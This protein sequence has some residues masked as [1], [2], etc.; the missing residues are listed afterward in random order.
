MKKIDEILKQSPAFKTLLK[1][2]G[3]IIVNDL[4]DEALLVTS[5]FLTLQKDIIVIK[6]NQYE[7]NLLYQQISLINEKD[8]LFFP[9]DESYRIEALASSPELLGQRIDALYQLTTDQPKILITHGQALVRYLP[10]R[11]LFLDNCLNLKTGMQI[12][13]YD[14]QKLLIKA[15]Y[16]SAPRVDQPFYFSQWLAVYLLQR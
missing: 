10:S 8:S 14:L 12:D 5:A 11:Q 13:I 4:N 2:E 6:P 7:A 3:N 16:T 9:V 15:G 1:G